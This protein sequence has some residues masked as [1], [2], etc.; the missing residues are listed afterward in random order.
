[1]KK[2]DVPELEIKKLSVQDVI[3]TSFTW[4]DG[5]RE[6]DELPIG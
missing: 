6:E 4:E 1:M 2:Y 3:A 5:N